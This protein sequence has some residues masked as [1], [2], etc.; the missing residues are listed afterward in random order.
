MVVNCITF[1]RLVFVHFESLQIWYSQKIWISVFNS[2]ETSY[3][4][5]YSNEIK[6]FYFQFT[7]YIN[8]SDE[9][10]LYCRVWN[11]RACRHRYLICS[12]IHPARCYMRLCDYQFYWLV[13]PARLCHSAQS[14]SFE[15]KRNYSNS[16]L[17]NICVFFCS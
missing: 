10:L 5:A 3:R 1:F 7:S 6:Q 2:Y 17:I 15:L 9:F 4:S 8:F 11:N 13:P 16:L 12:K 14:L